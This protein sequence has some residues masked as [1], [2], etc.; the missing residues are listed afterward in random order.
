MLQVLTA[1][2]AFLLLA[3]G[4]GKLLKPASTDA[5][6]RAI[7]TSRG[8]AR[9]L[10]ILVSLL[11]VALGVLMVFN[12]AVP[13]ASIATAALAAAFLGTHLMA[14][15]NG[16]DISCQC[17]GAVDTKLP[18][19]ISL[20]RSASFF[21]LSTVA[22]VSAALGGAAESRDQAHLPAVG[23]G[24][25]GALTFIL[26]FQLLGESRKLVEHDARVHASLVAK[27]AELTARIG[28]AD[29]TMTQ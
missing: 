29:H 19:R 18:G 28:T 17:F 14:Y 12:A 1:A 16:A 7:N 3:S 21:A 20:G 9:P 4:S 5:F 22:A 11:E 27:A 26:I 25:L 2:V 23:F 24:L 10:T 15:A 6:L 13:M 8:A